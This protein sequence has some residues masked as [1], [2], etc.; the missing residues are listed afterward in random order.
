MA[1]RGWGGSIA[2]AVGVAAG[3]GAAQLGLGYGLGIIA[4]VPSPDGSA[5]PVWVASLTWATWIAATSVIAGA[6]YGD[7]RSGP[8][9][10]AADPTARKV[11]GMLELVLWRIALCL[12]A[13]LGAAVTVALVAVPAREA[14][15]DYTFAPETIAAGYTVIGVLVGLAVSFAA[16]SSAAIAA[17]VIITTAWLWLLAIAA[18]VDG[19]MSGR[20]FAGA[21]LGVWRITDDGEGYWIRSLYWPGAVISLTS[22][23]VAGLVSAW[24]GGR[25]TDSKVGVSVSGAIGPILVA[26]AYFMA[27][28]RPVGMESWQVSA[29]LIAPYAVIAGLLGS[30]IIAAAT[31]RPS[32]E[33][34]LLPVDIDDEDPI[35][36]VRPALTASPE[37]LR[38]PVAVPAQP[39]RPQQNPPQPP[40]PGTPEP[41]SG[42]PKLRLKPKSERPQLGL[43]E[44]PEQEPASK[45]RP[46][47]PSA[48]DKTTDKP[49]DKPAEPVTE[50]H[51]KPT[52][53]A[54]ASVKPKPGPPPPSN[55]AP[56]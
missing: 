21:Q 37:P 25:R 54:R 2:S 48:P 27:A 20:G 7:R 4:W 41:S 50:Q 24:W 16:I 34:A 46:K 56:R 22:A 11:S 17:N 28:P 1:V 18:T 32:Y 19:A 5:E 45:P 13:A 43:V 3:T 26:A 8:S 14:A 9:A 23:L 44:E 51:P 29:Y 55:P 40:V 36:P 35:P 53:R 39:A 31:P 52:G 6:V 15:Q 42:P 10:L 12:A 30:V 38:P 33:R 47:R 49:T